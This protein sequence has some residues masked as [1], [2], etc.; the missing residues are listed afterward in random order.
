MSHNPNPWFFGF[1]RSRAIAKSRGIPN[2]G[3]VLGSAVFLWFPTI[4]KHVWEDIILYTTS[5][6]ELKT[7]GTGAGNG[8]PMARGLSFTTLMTRSTRSAQGRYGQIAIRAV[9]DLLMFRTDALCPQYWTGSTATC[10]KKHVR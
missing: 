5:L 8:K 2:C 10:R 6:I 3:G 7:G 4:P 1:S 9:V